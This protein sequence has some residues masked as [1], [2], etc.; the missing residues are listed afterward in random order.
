MLTQSHTLHIHL[1]LFYWLLLYS[2]ACP[3]SL[4]APFSF[5]SPPV[6]LLQLHDAG[7]YVLV[8]Y[9]TAAAIIFIAFLQQKKKACCRVRIQIEINLKVYNTQEVNYFHLYFS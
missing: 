5:L 8:C 4:I 1:A 6:S 2:P 9:L 3:P 7:W